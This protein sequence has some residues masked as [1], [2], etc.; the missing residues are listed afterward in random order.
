MQCAARSGRPVREDMAEM[1]AAACAQHLGADHPVAGVRLRSIASSEA[2]RVERGQ[3]QPE[4]YFVSDSN[5]SLRTR[6]TGTCRVRTRSRTRPRT[7]LSVLCADCTGDD[8]SEHARWRLNSHLKTVLRRERTEAPF[9]GEYDFSFEPRSTG[10]PGAEPSCSNRRR[11]PLRL[12]W[13]AFYSPASEKRSR[14]KTDA[15]PRDDPHRG[16]V[17]QAAAVISAMSSRTGPAPTGQRY[18]INSA[19][20][21]LEEE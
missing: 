2:R 4:S 8:N 17:A 12:R 21:K 10:A 6:R 19:A 7:A 16:A 9:S 11:N 18:C 20:W 5:S 1:T 3:P 15:S 13:P 14:R